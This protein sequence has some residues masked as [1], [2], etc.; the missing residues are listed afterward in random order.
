MPDYERFSRV[1]RHKKRR[2]SKRN[3]ILFA[4]LS[5]FFFI[6]LISLIT[7]GNKKPEEPE[8]SQDQQTESKLDSDAQSE[9][10]TEEVVLDDDR[11][12]SNEKEG[13]GKLDDANIEEISSDKDDVIK[14]YIGDWP[15]IGT[16]QKGPH[17]TNYSGGSQDRKEIKQ[18]VSKTT[19]IVENE[20]IEHWVG[21]GGD[22]K[23]E[24]TVSDQAKE[25]YY[26][27]YLSWIDEE[28]WQVT[29]VEQI[30]EFDE[31]DSEGSE[32]E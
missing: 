32:Q 22:Q 23:V 11:D 27:V 25:N 15:P 16:S 12:D 24:A 17:T 7:F 19:G 14:A 1:E 6:I 10:E 31:T 5:A 2:N 9:D 30:T 21:N 20:M 3:L 13:N 8:V 18:A 4:S 29:K 28:G 26:R